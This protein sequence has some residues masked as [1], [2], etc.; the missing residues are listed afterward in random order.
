MLESMTNPRPVERPLERMARAIVATHLDTLVDRSDDG[1]AS[2][3]PDGLIYL[4]D[5]GYAPLEVVS[6]HDGDYN[7]LSDALAR[8]GETIATNPTDPGWYVA[9]HHRSNLK[10]AH[11]ASQQDG[12]SSEGLRCSCRSFTARRRSSAHRASAARYD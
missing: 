3:Q 5:G 1:T 8:Q 6:D 9:L 4:T 10:R 12:E 11:I 2:G 7:R